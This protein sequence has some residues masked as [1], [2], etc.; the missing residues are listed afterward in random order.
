MFKEGRLL[1][2]HA[3]FFIEMSTN[4]CSKF[5]NFLSTGY[6]EELDKINDITIYIDSYEGDELKFF[7]Q[8]KSSVRVPPLSSS[9]KRS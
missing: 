3:I 6:K 8:K 4:K 2:S 1:T 5:S 7:I 9:V